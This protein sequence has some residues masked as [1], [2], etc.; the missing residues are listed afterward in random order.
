[1]SVAEFLYC[2]TPAGWVEAVHDNLEILLIDHANCE[3]KAASTAMNLMYRYIDKPEM[4][5][6]LSK[7]AREELRHFEQVVALLQKRNIAYSNV[8]SGRYAGELRKGVRTFEPARLIDI[9]IV[10][11]IVEAR[12]CE[13]FGKVI[14]VLDDELAD[15]YTS[16]LKSEAR[17]FRIYLDFAEQYT[18]QYAS[19]LKVPLA[20]R[21]AFFLAEDQRLVQFPDP[22]FRFHSGLPAFALV[23]S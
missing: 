14:A 18:K 8:P 12:S 21:I 9:L 22:E 23:A 1:M 13:R 15:F 5:L 2:E 7:L 6:Q 16:L 3:K 4:L 20:E 17:H 10:G 11:A 19:Q